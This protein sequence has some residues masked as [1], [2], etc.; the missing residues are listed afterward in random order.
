MKSVLKIVVVLLFAA[1]AVIGLRVLFGPKNPALFDKSE[2]EVKLKEVI[3]LQS[4]NLE[5]QPGGNEYRGTGTKPDGTV[6]DIVVK[7]DAQARKID[8]QLFS[9]KGE[10]ISGGSIQQHVAFPF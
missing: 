4:I 9:T 5:K 1:V 8:Y 2:L 10:F 3:I 6:Y 7:L